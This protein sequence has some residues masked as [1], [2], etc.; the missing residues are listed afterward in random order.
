MFRSSGFAAEGTLSTRLDRRLIHTEPS[1][2]H[3]ALATFR[4]PFG[5]RARSISSVDAFSGTVIATATSD[6]GRLVSAARTNCSSNPNEEE[7]QA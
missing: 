6:F 5:S 4:Q 2:T 1:A 7:L 3:S